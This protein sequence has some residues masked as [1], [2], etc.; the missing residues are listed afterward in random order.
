MREHF[1]VPSIGSRDVSLSERPNIGR[2][3]H[4]LYLLN[5]VNDAFNVHASHHLGESGLGQP[6][7]V[8]GV[9]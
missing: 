7:G 8:I 4:L 2:F 3:E 1:I 6:D 9:S 5:L